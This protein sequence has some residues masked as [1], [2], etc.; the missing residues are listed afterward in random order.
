VAISTTATAQA[1]TFVPSPMSGS[2]KTFGAKGPLGKLYPR[3]AFIMEGDTPSC[4]GLIDNG[5]NA[6]RRPDWGGW[7]G[8]Y[9]YRQPRGETH[10]IWTQGGDMFSRITSQD[11]IN[12]H[13]SDQ[14]TIWRWREAFQ[15]DVAARMDWTIADYRHANHN[16]AVEI[17]GQGGTAPLMIEAEV[18]KSIELDTGKSHDPD[19]QKLHYSWFQYAEAGPAAITITGAD[20]PKPVVSP[21]ATCRPQWLPRRGGC[22]PAGTAHLILAVTDEGTPKL[23]SYRR[24]ILNVF[25]TGKNPI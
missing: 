14:A 24:I 9:I 5:L 1:R 12:D 13:T 7:G 11:T 18:G 6:Y 21:T 4:L 10:P 23:T 25:T 8:R 2:M 17:N 22:P 19:G 3:F 15:N 16:P 20:T